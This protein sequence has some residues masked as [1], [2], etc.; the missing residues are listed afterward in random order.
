MATASMETPALCN[1]RSFPVTA[2]STLVFMPPHSP[3]SVVTTITPAVL[4]S[5]SFMNG[6]VYS[7]F[8]WPR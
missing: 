5:F 4:A 8:A 1:S 2:R 3:L 6:C 7:G